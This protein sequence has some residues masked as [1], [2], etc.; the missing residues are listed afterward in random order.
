MP[1]T[2][3][4][5]KVTGKDKKNSNPRDFTNGDRIQHGKRTGLIWQ[6]RG[7]IALVK[8]D[9]GKE[10]QFNLR[11][12]DMVKKIGHEDN[13]KK[14]NSYKFLPASGQISRGQNRYGNVQ[15]HLSRGGEFKDGNENVAYIREEVGT[16]M[17]QRDRY[18]A[19]IY[20]GP[21]R[22]P[23]SNEPHFFSEQEAVDYLKSK[24]FEY[25]GN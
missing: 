6:I 7:D 14:S 8:W 2:G 15:N 11:S 5:F 24:G 9:D 20:N 19:C 22:I 16:H 3:L 25:L 21:D 1:L 23:A 12:S 18:Y 17:G 10:S 13:N 4:S